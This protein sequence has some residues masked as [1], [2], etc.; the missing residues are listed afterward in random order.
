MKY[1][2]NEVVINGS[3]FC[4]EK[5]SKDLYNTKWFLINYDVCEMLLLK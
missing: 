1:N 3:K 4:S 2:R 5:I